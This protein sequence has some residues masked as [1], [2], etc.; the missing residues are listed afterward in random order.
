M[1]E[2]F[3]LLH[4]NPA[5]GHLSI[6]DINTMNIQKFVND[7]YKSGL[8]TASIRKMFNI[9]NQALNH[10]V[11]GNM[12]I[13]NPAESVHLPKHTQKQIKVFTQEEQDKFLECAKDD[14]LYGLFVLALDTGIRLGCLLREA[15]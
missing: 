9:I 13:R 3:I 2:R 8:S 15:L 5:I 12:I 14:A 6:K 4:I 10:A 7:K 11:K 1:Y